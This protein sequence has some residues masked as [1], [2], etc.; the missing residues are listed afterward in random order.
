MHQQALRYIEG[1]GKVYMHDYQNASNIILKNALTN[2]DKYQSSHE[3]ITAIIL[4]EY[5]IKYE[6]QKKIGKHTVGFFISNEKI[7]LEVDG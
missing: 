3:M 5:G 6:L 7:V 2:Y 1:S 4:T